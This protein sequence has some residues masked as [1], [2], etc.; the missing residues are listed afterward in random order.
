MKVATDVQA[1]IRNLTTFYDFSGKS[2]IHVGA[3]GGQLIDKI[4]C[5]GKPAIERAS[6]FEGETGITIPMRY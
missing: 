2:I 1:L 6:R 3:G 4:F 5:L